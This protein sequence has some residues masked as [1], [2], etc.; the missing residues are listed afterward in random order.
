MYDQVLTPS[1]FDT[2]KFTTID[3]RAIKKQIGQGTNHFV[4]EY[5]DRKVIKIP[6]KKGALTYSTARLL[7]N[8]IS[9]LAKYFPELAVNTELVE[10]ADGTDYCLI[11]ELFIH[12]KEISSES[13]SEVREE[14]EKILDQNK[15]L[16]NETGHA[17][18]LFGSDG[19]VKSLLGLVIPGIKPNLSNLVMRKEGSRYKVYLLDTELLRLRI[20]SQRLASLPAWLQS[21]ISFY[22]TSFLLKVAFKFSRA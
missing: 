11:Q 20:N 21:W 6:K 22:L 19:F 17:L 1:M 2:S 9:L 12:G 16:Y 3:R 5:Q 7:K 4:Y 18:D 15:Q 13:M 14:L 10:S 8:D